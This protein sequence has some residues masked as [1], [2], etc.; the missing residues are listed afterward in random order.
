[1]GLTKNNYIC[2]VPFQRLEVAEHKRFLCC[3]SWL[4]KHLP[5]D[6]NPYEAWNS[7]DA[8]KIRS[9]ILDGSYE[10]CDSKQCPHLLEL[11]NV[12]RVGKNSPLLHKNNIPLEFE[13]KIKDHVSGKITSPDIVDFMM[14]RSCNLKCPSCRLDMII[15]DSK[16]IE[17]VK[18]DILDIETTFG[19][20]IK[21]LYI[22]GSGDP[23]IS[24]GFRDF[25]RTFDKSKWTSLKNIHLH[26]NATYWTPKMWESMEVVHPYVGSCEISID[27]ATKDTYE[28]KVRLNGEWDLLLENLKFISTIKTLRRIKISFVVQKD[29]YKEMKLFYDLISDIFKGTNFSIFYNRITNWGTFT[30][31]EFLDKDVCNP[32]HKEH[33]LFVEEINKVIPAENSYT[34]LQEFVNYKK[35]LI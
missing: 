35:V 7:N 25:L 28:N 3:A 1:M 32:N 22:T 13:Q 30:D 24:V 10:F 20:Y 34:N 5:E 4:T 21:T 14:D 19:N 31:T 18:Q 11:E 33:H 17:K 9:S 2:A 15:A 16:K 29:N 27:A 23:F 12:G 26:T 8:R 6:S